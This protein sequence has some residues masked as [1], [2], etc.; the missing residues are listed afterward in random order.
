MHSYLEAWGLH[1]IDNCIKSLDVDIY[2]GNLEDIMYMHFSSEFFIKFLYDLD[3]IIGKQGSRS[4]DFGAEIRPQS[5]CK[6][7]PQFQTK[8]FQFDKKKNL[9]GGG[10]VG[11]GGM[12]VLYLYF[13]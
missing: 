6:F 13:I 4:P 12:G 10:G 1:C 7:F 3:N 8:K 2:K 11:G 5:Q 9:G